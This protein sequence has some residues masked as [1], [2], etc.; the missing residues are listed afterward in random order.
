MSYKNKYNQYVISASRQLVY[1]LHQD[2]ILF[3]LNAC[4]IREGNFSRYLSAVSEA[5]EFG[6]KLNLC[7]FAS[8]CYKLDIEYSSKNALD[9]VAKLLEVT[10]SEFPDVTI[11]QCGLYNCGE[12]DMRPISNGLKY[13]PIE[14]IIYVNSI[15]IDALKKLG[16]VSSQ[17]YDILDYCSDLSQIIPS[18]MLKMLPLATEQNNAQYKNI[19]K[20]IEECQIDSR[21]CNI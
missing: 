12:V 21:I 11:T 2:V 3:N 1:T 14:R 6:N 15:I 10:K 13:D 7:N 5:L 18:D 9:F 17:L 8:L 20:L 4:F 16:Y 19:C